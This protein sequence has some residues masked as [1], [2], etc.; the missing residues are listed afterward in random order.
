MK[1]CTTKNKRWILLVSLLLAVVITVGGAL[2][3]VFTSS[4]PV[5]NIFDPGSVNVNVYEN[6]TNGV[7]SDVK[8]T[9]TGE[10]EAYVRVAVVINWQDADGNV[11]FGTPTGAK[12]DIEWNLTNSSWFNG[13]D[14]YYYYSSP[15]SVGYSTENL[16]N[17]CK[18]TST[19]DGYKLVVEIIAEAIQITPSTVVEEAWPVDVQNDGNLVLSD[20]T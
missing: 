1:F 8:V 5:I 14:G 20:E 9:N 17:S 18:M 19:A 15:V 7:K 16:I 2:A 12:A 10:T 3:Y 13:G 11:Y 4:G 6:I